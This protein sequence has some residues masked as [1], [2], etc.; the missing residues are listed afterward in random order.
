MGD[1]PGRDIRITL[2]MWF[3]IEVLS[4]QSACLAP[5]LLL[6]ETPEMPRRQ[7]LNP[8]CWGTP[9]LTVGVPILP[10]EAAVGAQQEQEVVCDSRRV[11]DIWFACGFGVW[12]TNPAGFPCGQGYSAV[13]SPD[14]QH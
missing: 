9:R 14:E 13:S 7:D 6:E 8:A 2:K 5:W 4:L 12:G 11:Q 10:G 3:N 1:G